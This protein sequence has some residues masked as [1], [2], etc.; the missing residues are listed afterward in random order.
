MAER[1]WRTAESEQLSDE[2]GWWKAEAA[3]LGDELRRLQ[4]AHAVL[5]HREWFT[6]K[7]EQPGRNIAD[8]EGRYYLYF[9]DRQ[10][11]FPCCMLGPKDVLLIGRYNGEPERE[12][13]V[14]ALAGAD[15]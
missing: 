6:L 14:E 1:D 12:V 13:A 10:G 5:A 11:T 9:C 2:L 8:E 3:R 4:V 7:V 15:G